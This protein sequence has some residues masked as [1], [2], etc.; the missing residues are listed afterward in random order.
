MNTSGFELPTSVQAY[1]FDP[2][3]RTGVDALLTVGPD[4]LPAGLEW[5]E[6]HDYLAART[7]TELTRCEWAIMVRQ[8]W[9]VVWK[10]IDA[11]IWRPIPPPELVAED[12]AVTPYACWDAQ[13]FSLY[14]ECKELYLYTGVGVTRTGTQLAFSLETSKKVLL[15][16]DAGQ[17]R[18]S[19]QGTWSGWSVASVPGSPGHPDFEIARLQSLADAALARV[20]PFTSS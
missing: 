20:R 10:S 14:H 1:L 17:F 18:W 16:E 7:A 5:S 13:G 6:L 12:C 11:D 8:L 9:A 2:V 19:E 4:D 15:G 3:V